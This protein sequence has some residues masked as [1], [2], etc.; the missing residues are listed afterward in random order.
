M[1]YLLIPIIVL[2]GAGIA[3]QAATNAR[4]RDAVGSPTLSAIVNSAVAIVFLS[5]VTATG[6][7]GRGRPAGALSA[8]WWA[9]TSG[10]I[11]AA[12]VTIALVSVGR[13]GATVTFAAVI[14]GQI[15]A[16]VLIDTFGWLNVPRVPLGPARVGGL[17]LLVAGVALVRWGSAPPP[18][19]APAAA[20]AAATD[21]D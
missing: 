2:A 21:E 6:V 15:A 4:M 18:P 8:P 17:L 16:A 20:D 14:G 11:G 12:Y 7:F 3:V 10:L 9:W 13:V 5:I 19:A 1:K